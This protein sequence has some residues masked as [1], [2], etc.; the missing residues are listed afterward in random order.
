MS[1]D[2]EVLGRHI[3]H[4]LLAIATSAANPSWPL[5][6]PILTLDDQLVL[7]ITGRLAPGDS[8]HVEEALQSVLGG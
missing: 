8:G 5:D 1:S 6:V 2:P 4:S 7:R 3:G